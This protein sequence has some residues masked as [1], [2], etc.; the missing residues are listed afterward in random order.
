MRIFIYGDY[1]FL[2]NIYG[3]SG[4]SGNLALI[5]INKLAVV[6][7]LLLIIVGRHCCLWCTID[8]QSMQHT[9]AERGAFPLRTLEML[10][11]EYGNFHHQGSKVQ[12]KDFKNVIGEALFQVPLDQVAIIHILLL[13]DN[14]C[15]KAVTNN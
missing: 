7:A 14:T 2:T 6:H 1:Q 11:R 5:L 9:P 15:S 10:T 8:R 13:Y 4:A 12:A 3:L